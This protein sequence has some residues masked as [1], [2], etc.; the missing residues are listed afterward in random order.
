MTRG[1]LVDR[2]VTIALLVYGLLN[3]ALSVPR[4]FALAEGADGYLGLLGMDEPLADS[5][6]ASLWGAVAAIVFI[7][8]WAATAWLSWR[9]LQRGRIA[10]WVPLAGAVVSS[11]LAATC[12]LI[13]TIADPAFLEFARQLTSR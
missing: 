13:P 2:I 12:I 3:V 9:M 8:G 10:F 6:A 4:M 5:R 7:A 1:R 11:V